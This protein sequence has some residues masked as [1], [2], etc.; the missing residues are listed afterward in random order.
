MRKI[1]QR[2]LSYFADT[3]RAGGLLALILQG[4]VIGKQTRGRQRRSRPDD[5]NEW[6][7]L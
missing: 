7:Y 2:Q 3:V 5:I 4:K 1:K 6:E